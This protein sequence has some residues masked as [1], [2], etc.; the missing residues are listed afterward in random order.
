MKLFLDTNVVIDYLAAREP[1]CHDIRKIIQSCREHDIQLFVSSITFTTMEYVLK[2][3]VPHEL[4][5]KQFALLRQMIGVLPSDADSID[6]SIVSTFQDFEDAVQYYTALGHTDLIL[7][8]NTKDFL[9]YSQ[10]PVLTPTEF[11]AQY[12]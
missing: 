2:R 10:M 11:V 7:T 6:K 5:M 4:L 12:F 3:H 9:P 8:R 1:F